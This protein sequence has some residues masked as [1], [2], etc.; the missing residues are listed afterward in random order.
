MPESLVI[1]QPAPQNW[2]RYSEGLQTLGGK[3]VAFLKEKVVCFL[4]YYSVNTD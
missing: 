2:L 1:F 4:K 3:G